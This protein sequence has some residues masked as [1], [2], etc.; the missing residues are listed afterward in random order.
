MAAENE[1]FVFVS[2]NGYVISYY[3]G[4]FFFNFVDFVFV[5]IGVKIKSSTIIILYK[6]YSNREKK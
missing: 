4:E 5:Y 3:P 6:N 1:I 2:R